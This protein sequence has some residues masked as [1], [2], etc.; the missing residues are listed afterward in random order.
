M[1]SSSGSEKGEHNGDRQHGDDRQ[2]GT[3]LATKSIVIQSKRFYLDVKQNQ[4]GRFIKFAEVR[5]RQFLSK[6]K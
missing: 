1:S 3:E 2:G 5:T 4:R 6:K